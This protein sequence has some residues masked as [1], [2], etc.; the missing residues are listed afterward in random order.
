MSGALQEGTVFAGRYC[1][2]CC[3][4]TGAMRAAYEGKHLGTERRR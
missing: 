4:A 3:I 1:M 2:V